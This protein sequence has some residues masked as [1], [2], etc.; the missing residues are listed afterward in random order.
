MGGYGGGGTGEAGAGGG[1]GY[2]GGGAGGYSNSGDGGGGGSFNGGT[3]QTN[4]ALVGT[5]AGSASIVATNIVAPPTVLTPAD[6]ATVA[7][8]SGVDFTYTYNGSGGNPQ[9]GY[10]LKRNAVTLGQ[11]GPVYQNEPTKQIYSAICLAGYPY[12]W[13]YRQDGDVSVRLP[14]PAILPTGYG[15]DPAW[16]PDATY[17]A[18]PTSNTGIF[19]YKRSGN[20][21]TKLADPATMPGPNGRQAAFSPDGTYLAVAGLSTPYLTIYKRSGDTFTKLADPATMPPGSAYGVSFSGDG[22]LLAVA[23]AGTPYITIYQRSGDTFTK[24]PDPAVL[25]PN[26]CYGCSFSENSTYLSVTHLQQPYITIYKISGTTFTKLPNPQ[27]LPDSTATFSSWSP[28]NNYLTVINNSFTVKMITYRRIGDNFA[29]IASPASMPTGTVRG[30]AW[31]WDSKYLSITSSSGYLKIYERQGDTLT[32]LD[33]PTSMPPGAPLGNAYGAEALTPGTQWWNGTAWVG[34]ETEVASTAQ[35]ISTNGWPV[36]G[37][38]YQYA[39]ADSNAFG[40]GDYS[41]YGTLNPYEWWD[42][43][44]WVPMAENWVVSTSSE[45]T[46]SAVQNGLVKDFGYDWTV[47][48][49]GGSTPLGPY[50]PMFFFTGAVDSLIPI[51]TGSAW[52]DHN[53]L[54]RINSSTWAQHNAVIW[55]GSAWVPH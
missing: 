21:F 53:I 2:G 14:D 37:N 3:N 25:P 55:D 10:A 50:A 29:A 15:N 30:S 1:G 22:N 27:Q 41:A 17:L 38:T 12:V 32:K 6:N 46:L 20:T 49:K 13:L 47:A 18:I 36:S 19:I 43:A 23:H 4:T 16:S 51:W 44:A 5:A 45:V 28:D 54:I 7:L 8:T 26:Y 52:L 48:T 33:N 42:G 11:G 24:L 9:A 40:L 34:V 39:M 35:P 31:S